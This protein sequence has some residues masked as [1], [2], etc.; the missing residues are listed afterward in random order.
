M[1]ASNGD[2]GIIVGDGVSGVM[3][4]N[5]KNVDIPLRVK[6]RSAII[7]I[8]EYNDE[9]NLFDFPGLCDLFM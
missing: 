9:K 7:T 5:F 1:P 3:K 8:K 2:I 4:N 6:E